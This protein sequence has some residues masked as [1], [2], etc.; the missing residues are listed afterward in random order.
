MEAIDRM[1]TL[2]DRGVKR[3]QERLDE[4]RTGRDRSRLLRELGEA[5]HARSKGVSTSDAEVSR[6]IGAID[7]LDTSDGEDRQAAD[8]E[9]QSARSEIGEAS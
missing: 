7:E 1:R 8:V 6:L 9:T 3:G 5:C 4:V 2:L